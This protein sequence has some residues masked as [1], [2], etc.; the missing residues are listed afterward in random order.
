MCDEFHWYIAC[1]IY[2]CAEI[3]DLKTVLVTL[4]LKCCSACCSVLQCI[5]V[6]CIVL[7]CVA[8]CC[9]VLQCV[10]ACGS[11]LQC[12]DRFQLSCI[13][14]QI[15]IRDAC[16]TRQYTATHGNTLQH[17]ATH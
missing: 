16:N 9:G 17:T 2:R 11:V 5:T 1:L 4:Q 12:V 13:M 10:A 15:N 14:P 8:V 7:Q 6:C 3:V